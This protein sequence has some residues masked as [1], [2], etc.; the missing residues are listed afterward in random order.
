MFVI[1]DEFVS[2][3]VFNA[4]MDRMEALME[5]TLTEMKMEVSS[6]ISTMRSENE[7][8]RAEVKEEINGLH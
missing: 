1:A 4:R 7:K 3:E 2:K 5:K 6:A 8:F